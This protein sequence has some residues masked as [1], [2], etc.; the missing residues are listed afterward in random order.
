MS[1]Q[2]PPLTSGEH[3]IAVTALTNTALQPPRCIVTVPTVPGYGRSIN[4]TAANGGRDRVAP[5]YGGERLGVIPANNW[6]IQSG[7]RAAKLCQPS[8]GRKP[9]SKIANWLDS[10][11][12]PFNGI[13]G[14][15]IGIGRLGDL[16]PTLLAHDRLMSVGFNAQNGMNLSGIPFKTLST[17]TCSARTVPPSQLHLT[18]TAR[19]CRQ[20]IEGKVLPPQAIELTVNGQQQSFPAGTPTSLAVATELSTDNLDGNI[21]IIKGLSG[22]KY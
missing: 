17:Y 19:Q 4:V 20:K 9:K 14:G 21:V 15:T 2:T 6:N 12:Q 5:V 3:V 18:R 7:Q 1:Q 16:P 22:P 8:S 13:D 11:L 10:D